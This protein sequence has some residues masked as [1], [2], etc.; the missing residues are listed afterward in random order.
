MLTCNMNSSRSRLRKMSHVLIPGL[1]TP[2]E[3]YALKPCMEE[4]LAFSY[5]LFSS[6]PLHSTQWAYGVLSCPVVDIALL[7]SCVLSD[8]DCPAHR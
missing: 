5:H 1:R 8:L 2:G 3:P 4:L 7:R 6:H